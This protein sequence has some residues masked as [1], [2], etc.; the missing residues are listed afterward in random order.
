MGIEGGPDPICVT[1]EAVVLGDAIVVRILPSILVMSTI[2]E[3]FLV[4]HVC[5]SYFVD[6]QIPSRY[7]HRLFSGALTKLSHDQLGRTRL[8]QAA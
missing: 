2:L 7:G 4:H 3:K 1:S 8:I 5:V 6:G